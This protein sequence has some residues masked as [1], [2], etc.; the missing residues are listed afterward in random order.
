MSARSA[1]EQVATPQQR[2]GMEVRDNQAAVQGGSSRRDPLRRAAEHSVEPCFDPRDTAVEQWP[3]DE[4]G[5]SEA[6][7]E[8]GGAS[9][10]SAHAVSVAG[11]V[12][13]LPS[14]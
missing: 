5:R 2:I 8:H 7:A 14:A 10:H 12:T 13:S 11:T 1:G 3:G 4:C 9:G 6:R